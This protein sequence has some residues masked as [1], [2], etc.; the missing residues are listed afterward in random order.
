MTQETEVKE[1]TTT[2]TK[3][4]LSHIQNVDCAAML[5]LTV[6]DDASAEL[7]ARNG[8]LLKS[9]ISDIELECKKPKKALHELHVWIC[10]TEK[11]AV[12]PLRAALDHLEKQVAGWMPRREERRLALESKLKADI[13]ELDPWMV[14]EETP[15]I[16]VTPP[17]AGVKDHFKPWSYEL[18]NLQQ[19]LFAVSRDA[20]LL[21]ELAVGNAFL[22]NPDFWKPKSKEMQADL[23]KRYPGVEGVRGKKRTI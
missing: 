15:S 20:D 23:S 1:L 19:L 14:P 18:T 4:D 9:I 12:E 6:D 7:A 5:L 22:L 10:D 3:P 21:R 11:R 2:I 16:P 13:E 17:P 8:K